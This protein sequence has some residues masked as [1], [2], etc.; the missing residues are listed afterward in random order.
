MPA[1]VKSTIGEHRKVSAWNRAA[2]RAVLAIE[3]LAV[4]LARTGKSD[5]RQSS[6]RVLST[7][8]RLPHPRRSVTMLIDAESYFGASENSLVTWRDYYC[9]PAACRERRNWAGEHPNSRLNARLNAASD[10]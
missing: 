3:N 4:F 9:S 2:H 5:P 7:I 8:F 6:V 1:H 10:A